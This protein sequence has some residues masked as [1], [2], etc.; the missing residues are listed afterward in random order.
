MKKEAMYEKLGAMTSLEVK[1]SFIIILTSAGERLKNAILEIFQEEDP[2]SPMYLI[3]FSGA[4][5]NLTQVR[6]VVG[7]RCL[8]VDPIGKL[9]EYPIRSNF[10]E[11]MTMT[12]FLLSCY[13]SRKGVV[14]TALRTARAG[15]L[16]RRLV[17]IT[18]FQVISIR[19]CNTRR[20]IRLFPLKSPG[21]QIILSITDRRKGRALSS[22]IPGFRPRNLFLNR[23]L[24]RLVITEYPFAS[25]RSSLVCR[26]PFLASLMLQ[27]SNSKEKKA[28]YE[29][30]SSPTFSYLKE[31]KRAS[32]F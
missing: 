9:V 18:H 3:S 5:G 31:E 8:M 11:G 21:G 2:F 13:G 17:D 30:S 1:E 27:I 12:E 20:G 28:R 15:Y 7:I 23:D 10:K 25:I 14:D 6:Q 22:P 26:A 19:D 32:L 4:R 16:T 29:N 24:S